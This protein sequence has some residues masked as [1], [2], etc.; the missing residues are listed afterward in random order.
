MSLNIIK[1]F[2]KSY[3]FSS[4][5]DS[6]IRRVALV[7]FISLLLSVAALILTMSVMKSLNQNTKDRLLTIEPHLVLNLPSDFIWEQASQIPIIQELNSVADTKIIPIEKQDIILRSWNGRFQGAVGM[8]ISSEDMKWLLSRVPHSYENMKTELFTQGHFI[9]GADLM[10]ILGVLPGDSVYVLLPQFLIQSEIQ[11]P[12]LQKF[13]VLE[14]W[15]TQNPDIDLGYFYYDRQLGQDFLSKNSFLNKYIY[16]WL[17]QADLAEEFKNKYKQVMVYPI[18]TWSERNESLFFALKLEKFLVSLFLTLSVIVAGFSLVMA[19]TLVV[20]QKKKDFFILSVLG[21]SDKR[22][23]HLLI[24]ISVFLGIGGVISGVIVGGLLSLY[25]QY[26]PIHIWPDI[27]YESAIQA[28]VD[29]PMIAG[30]ILFSFV[31]AWFVTRQLMRI[32]KK[33]SLNSVRN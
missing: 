7:S 18:E 3:F 6:Q 20:F 31:M 15:R 9:L 27:Y 5:S 32:L 29:Y 19:L 28:K 1:I 2:I 30:V 24:G 26:F 22:I 21:L 12:R 4:R 17:S 13:Q 33:T 14:S 10:D 23:Y 16:I 8:G 25:L 11:V